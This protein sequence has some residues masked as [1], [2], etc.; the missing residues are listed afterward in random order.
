MVKTTVGIFGIG[1]HRLR[2]KRYQEDL[3]QT[4]GVYG[5]Q[6]GYFVLPVLGPTTA[7]D[8]IAM[9][10]DTFLDPFATMTWNKRSLK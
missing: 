1:D 7:R 2:G 9:F 4:L 6:N 8:A 10:G 3:S 5:V